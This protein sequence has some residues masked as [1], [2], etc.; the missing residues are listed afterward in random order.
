MVVGAV[1]QGIYTVGKVVFRFRKQIYRTLVA[2]DRAIDRAFK[3][4]G[5]GLQTRRGA[6]HGALG[7]SIIG[8][9][10]GS[11]AEDSPGNGIQSP[12][13]PK[14]TSYKPD[15]TR[16]GPPRR[17]SRRG[18]TNYNPRQYN[19]RTYAR[20]YEQCRDRFNN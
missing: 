5:Y 17:D 19:R 14:V 20:R 2:Q 1:A 4:G 15:K 12:I 16:S 6:R 8:S 13:K 10:I 18:R 9:I 7:G 3:V 11:Q